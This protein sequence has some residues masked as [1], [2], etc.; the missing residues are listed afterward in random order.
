MKRR[1]L[2]S[3]SFVGGSVGYVYE[4]KIYPD[5]VSGSWGSSTSEFFGDFTQMR[6]IIKNMTM[7]LGT[8]QD[9]NG[10]YSL[11]DIPN[12]FNVT[13]DDLRPTY[14]TYN[15]EYDECEIYFGE[16]E[17]IYCSVTNDTLY[18]TLY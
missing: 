5:W 7:D 3:T 17:D 2:L 18:L 12:E 15:P 6:E 13:V 9:Y 14:I 11:S 10:S 8:Y 16:Y 1:A 4:L